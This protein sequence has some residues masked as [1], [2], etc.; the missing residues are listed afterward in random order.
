MTG[1]G[2]SR[3]RRLRGTV[4]LV[5]GEM[6]YRVAGRGV[7]ASETIGL[8]VTTRTI[9]V[10]GKAVRAYALLNASGAAGLSFTVGEAFKVR[11][12]PPRRADAGPLARPHAAECTGRRFKRR[13]AAGKEL[14]KSHIVV[15][16]GADGCH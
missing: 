7:L 13:A 14:I 2:I 6:A 12:N 16:C 8:D 10:K 5:A 15:V 11:L 1:E 3:R 4:G 9:E